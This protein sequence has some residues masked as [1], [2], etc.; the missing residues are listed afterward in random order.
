MES[1]SNHPVD[2]GQN[3]VFQS[4]D[5]VFLLILRPCGKLKG[6]LTSPSLVNSPNIMTLTGFLILIT[7]DKCPQI[8]SQ[9]LEEN[10]YTGS[11]DSYSKQYNMSFLNFW[12][13]NMW[14]SAV[15]LTVDA[16]LPILYCII[17]QNPKR[18]IHI[19]KIEKLK[20]REFI[21]FH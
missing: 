14:Q 11:S 9:A 4:I 8:D 16:Q 21:L 10:V 3:Y 17:R 20:W 13:K 18:T 6:G 19:C 2:P 12:E 5:V 15:F 1:S 7:L